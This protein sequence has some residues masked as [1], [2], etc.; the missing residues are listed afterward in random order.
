LIAGITEAQRAQWSAGTAADWA[1]E[2]FGVAKRHTY[3]LLPAPD[4]PNHYRL[5]ADYVADATAVTREQLSKAGVR[6]AFVLNR[7]LR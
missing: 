7:A 2:S 4:S 5:S 3:G 1:L 6:L